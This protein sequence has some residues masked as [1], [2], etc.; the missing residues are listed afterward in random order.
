MLSGNMDSWIH[1]LG[2]LTQL[3]AFNE[4]DI[5]QSVKTT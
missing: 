5:K 1:V 3:G 4:V 2:Q